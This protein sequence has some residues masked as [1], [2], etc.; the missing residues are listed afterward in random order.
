MSEQKQNHKEATHTPDEAAL[1]TEQATDEAFTRFSP[2]AEVTDIDSAVQADVEKYKAR[3]MDMLDAKGSFAGTRKA[4]GR[5]GVRAMHQLEL[6]AGGRAAREVPDLV[7]R[8]V[9][10]RKQARI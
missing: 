10:E 3:E 8:R 1:L 4:I 2:V 5:T 6:V 9:A 7:A